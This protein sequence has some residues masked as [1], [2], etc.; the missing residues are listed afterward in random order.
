[1]HYLA[2]VISCENFWNLTCLDSYLINKYI[3]CIEFAFNQQNKAKRSLLLQHL[4]LRFGGPKEPQIAKAPNQHNPAILSCLVLIMLTIHG[5]TPMG[6]KLPW[7]RL[8]KFFKICG[9]IST[10]I[11]QNQDADL[12]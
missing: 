6:A 7:R 1:M 9:S 12:H 10:C 3:G 8:V 11:E 5:R 2:R 4:E